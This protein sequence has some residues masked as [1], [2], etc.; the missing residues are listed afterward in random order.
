MKGHSKR[1][2]STYLASKNCNSGR[3]DSGGNPNSVLLI[4][5]KEARGY[6]KAK[7]EGQLHE[8]RGKESFSIGV[9]RLS[10]SGL[11]TLSS[12]SPQ[13]SAL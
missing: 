11:N 8:L 6:H 13:P 1:Q 9:N 3:K 12:E 2:T 4:G 5:W 10:C 7:E